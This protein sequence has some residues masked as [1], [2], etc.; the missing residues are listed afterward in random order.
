[1][2]EINEPSVTTKP[3]EGATVWTTIPMKSST[4]ELPEVL[5]MYT[6]HTDDERQPDDE[7][8]TDADVNLQYIN[9]IAKINF[10]LGSRIPKIFP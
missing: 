7:V 8:K 3:L 6:P 1:M 10:Y 5:A 9:L 4:T 2:L